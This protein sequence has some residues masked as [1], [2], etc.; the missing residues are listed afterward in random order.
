MLAVGT[1][2]NKKEQK[3]IELR[4]YQ[5]SAISQLESWLDV[6]EGNVCLCIPTAGGKSFILAEFFKRRLGEDPESR[7]LLLTHQKELVEQDY[8]AMRKIAPEFDCG[9]YVAGLGRKDRDSAITFASIQSI[10]RAEGLDLRY[11]YVVIDEAH[12][13]NIENKGIYRKF[14]ARLKEINPDI[15][16]IGLTAT[17]YRTGQ[18]QLTAEGGLF[19]EIINVISI[20][21]LQKKGY[22]AMLS[23]KQTALQYNLDGIGSRNGD[24]IESELDERVNVFNS[25]EAVAEE[26]ARSAERFSRHHIL[27]FCVS[28][29]HAANMAAQLSDKGLRCSY[30]ESGMSEERRDAVIADFKEGRTNAICNVGILT[31]G[32]DFPEIDMIVMLRPTL[33]LNLYVQSMGRGLRLK[34]DGGYCLVLDFAGNVSRFGPVDSVMPPKAP[35]K[36]EVEPYPR[37]KVCPDCGE[38]VSFRYRSCPCCGH[39]FSDE[40]ITYVLSTDVVNNLAVRPYKV[41]SWRWSVRTSKAGNRMVVVY[42]DCGLKRPAKAFYVLGHWNERVREIAEKGFKSILSQFGAGDDVI[43]SPYEKAVKWLNAMAIQPAYAMID[44]SGEY[45]NLMGFSTKGDLLKEVK[46]FFQ[47]VD[48]GGS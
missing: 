23:S 4:D 32:F 7:L 6:N 31:T 8:N 41:Y 24:Y 27:V 9:I 35:S 1:E 22:L 47:K 40:M 48:E 36:R 17:P 44:T 14:L 19:D 38:I 29:R 12:K 34:K 11:D 25:N 43:N 2:E 5:I 16:I 45:I 3:T 42:V 28:R 30:V 18:G 46:K 39:D 10:Y 13:V 15:R 21:S 37:T 26:V 20:R 33:S